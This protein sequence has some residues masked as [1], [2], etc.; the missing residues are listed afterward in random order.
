MTVGKTAEFLLS[1]WFGCRF[2]CRVSTMAARFPPHGQGGGEVHCLLTCHAHDER[3]T[4]VSVMHFIPT[5]LLACGIIL[6][7]NISSLDA[8]MYRLRM[9]RRF[10]RQKRTLGFHPKWILWIEGEAK[11]SGRSDDVIEATAS[12]A[13]LMSVHPSSDKSS[14]GVRGRA[15]KLVG[16]RPM[17]GS[18]SRRD[19]VCVTFCGRSSVITI[20]LW[21]HIIWQAC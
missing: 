2:S 9:P 1:F 3:V 20:D 5:V 8:M 7:I 14:S 4:C 15:R 12:S 19:A 10:K 21:L 16:G 18:S 17:N 6:Y 11:S 13:V